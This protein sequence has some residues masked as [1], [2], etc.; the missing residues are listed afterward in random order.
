MR[1]ASYFLRNISPFCYPPPQPPSYNHIKIK[2]I[3]AQTFLVSYSVKAKLSY[4]VVFLPLGLQWNPPEKEPPG[5]SYE[6]QFPLQNNVKMFTFK[7]FLL[8]TP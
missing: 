2:V 6:P 1:S 3:T 4:K 8:G 7:L 5:I